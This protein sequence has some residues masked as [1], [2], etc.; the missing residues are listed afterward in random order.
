MKPRFSL[1][2]RMTGYFLATAITVI[3]LVLAGV[4]FLLR[5]YTLEAKAEEM[6]TRGREMAQLSAEFFSGALTREQL[7][8][9]FSTVDP[10][11]GARIWLLDEERRPVVVSQAPRNPVPAPPMGE[12]RHQM[13][14]R[15][16]GP[17]N[18]KAGTTAEPRRDGPFH[19]SPVLEGRLDKAYAG[20]GQSMLRLMHPYYDEQML[21]GFF[22]VRHQGEVAGVLVLAASVQGMD[23]FLYQLY[24]FVAL[25]G[26][27]GIAVAV[28]AAFHL[29]GRL[30]RPLTAMQ[31]SA[32]RMAAGDYSQ[33]LPVDTNDEIGDLA[34]SLNKLARD[35]AAFVN[36]MT[37]LEGMRRDFV[38]NVSHELRTPLTIIR[39]YNEAMLDGTVTDEKTTKRYQE[40]IRDEVIRLERLIRELLDISRLQSQR[41]RFTEP[42]DLSELVEL[43]GR[44]WE[45]VARQKNIELQVAVEPKLRI[46]GNGDR[47]VQLL[48]I[49]LDNALKFTPAGAAVKLSLRRRADRA[50]LT[51]A[52]Q[53][54]GITPEALPFIWERFYKADKAHVRIDGGTG[55][56]L[57]IAREI[58]ERH[59][60]SVDVESVV[61]AGTTFTVCFPLLGEQKERI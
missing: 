60:A 32:A 13:G 14:M 53:G 40:F 33:H 15:M 21:I 5:D 39:G 57:A 30:A 48:V 46:H 11:L 10:L 2:W 8:D 29:S 7:A 22:P 19:G 26:V 44:R 45:D 61:G 28:L 49:F 6:A 18:G 12:R 56:G 17:D 54:C 55:L 58:I 3:V 1:R 25:A 43:A 51:V 4:T 52:D 27:V 38:A 24:G 36:K 9:Y 35:L 42:I 37:S 23:A 41:E 20:E 50:V 16:M 47:L 59:E 31:G 34:A